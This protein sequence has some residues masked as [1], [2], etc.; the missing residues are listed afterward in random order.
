[1]GPGK[2]YKYHLYTS[3]QGG[4]IS[5]GLLRVAILVFF[6]WGQ[7]LYHYTGLGVA[8]LFCSLWILDYTDIGLPFCF[9]AS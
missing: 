3:S 2:Q 9:M 1:M 8:I 4:N 6:M 7:P 5:F